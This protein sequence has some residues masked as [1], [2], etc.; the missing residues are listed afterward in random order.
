M[1]ISMMTRGSMLKCVA[2]ICKEEHDKSDPVRHTDG[3]LFHVSDPDPSAI[4]KT[5]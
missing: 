3:I 4:G 1:S 2:Y 5:K